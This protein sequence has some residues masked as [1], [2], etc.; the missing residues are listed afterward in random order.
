MLLTYND[1]LSWLRY[2]VLGHW[3]DAVARTLPAGDY[4][5]HLWIPQGMDAND[6]VIAWV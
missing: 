2:F 6:E 1:S 3:F 4:N 5:T